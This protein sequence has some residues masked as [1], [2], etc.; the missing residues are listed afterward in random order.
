MIGNKKKVTKQGKRWRNL[1][2]ATASVFSGKPGSGWQEK[3]DAKWG[4]ARAKGNLQ[5]YTRTQE[6]KQEPASVFHRSWRT[7]LRAAWVGT[8]AWGGEAGGPTGPMQM[9]PSGRSGTGCAQLQWHLGRA[10][11]FQKWHLLLLLHLFPNLAQVSLA[12]NSD[13]GLY[14]EGNSG[15][16]ISCLA[17]LTQYKVLQSQTE[18]WV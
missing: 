5:R 16:C 13:L 14:S 12:G 4:T 6:D 18:T 1:Q 7:N 15:K 8:P 10:L 9:K 11:S 17:W 3:L 2:K